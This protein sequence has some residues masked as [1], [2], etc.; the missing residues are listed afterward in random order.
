M[1]LSYLS[2]RKLGFIVVLLATSSFLYS[3][4][5]TAPTASEDPAVIDQIWQGASSK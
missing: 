3:Q 4:N 5:S 1:T 2:I